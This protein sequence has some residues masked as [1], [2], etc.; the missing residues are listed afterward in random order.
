[1]QVEDP[2]SSGGAEERRQGVLTH[3]PQGGGNEGNAADDALMVDQGGPSC[4][5]SLCVSIIQVEIN[6]FR[7][8]SANAIDT[9]Q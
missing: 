2:V 7:S 9:I 5:T 6:S 3:T 1:M 8:S 4:L